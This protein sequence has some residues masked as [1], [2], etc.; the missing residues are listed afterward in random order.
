MNLRITLPV[1]LCTASLCS[2]ATVASF[3]GGL[4]T[5]W[6]GNQFGAAPGP[7]IGSGVGPDGSDS[8]QVTTDG[9][10]GQNNTVGFNRAD[11]G[12]PTGSFPFSFQFRLGPALDSA[13]GFS[14]ALLPTGTYGN[15]GIAPFLSEDPAAAGVL[16]FGFDTWGNDAPTNDF[17]FNPGDRSNYNDISL[18]WNGASVAA[19][20]DPRAQGLT[21]DDNLWH[22]AFGSIDMVNARVS[23][24]V[25]TLNIFNN[26]AVPG[27]TPYEY[28][29][30]I[31]GRTGGQDENAWFDN[32]AV[33]IPEPTV[34]GIAALGMCFLARRRRK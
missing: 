14:V 33:G 31:G 24:T 19:N 26:V 12:A 13:D 29:L 10:N 7:I 6:V 22:T 4:D 16:A 17:G 1:L 32:I 34:T 21:I 30:G 5:P 28:R 15:S 23:L 11:V 3:D 18:Y 8:L 20:F 9:V 25:D 27:L 2:A